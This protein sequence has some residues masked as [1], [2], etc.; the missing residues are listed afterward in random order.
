MRARRLCSTFLVVAMTVGLSGTALAGQ[1]TTTEFISAGADRRSIR[2]LIQVCATGS[3]E[4]LGE[5]V[6]TV[7]LFKKRDGQWVRIRVKNA[8][9]GDN[10]WQIT[11][12][13]APKAGRCK[14]VALYRGSD[15]H[16]PSRGSVRGGCSEEGWI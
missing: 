6:V 9:E 12:H 15:T 16:E 4:C 10:V 7:K 11:F 3:N 13:D 5:G 8:Y 2:G 1:E 14:M